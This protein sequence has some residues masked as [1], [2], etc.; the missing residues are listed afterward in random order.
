MNSF[1]ERQI[2]LWG[3]ETQKSLEDKSIAIIG[4]GGL[5]CSLGFA[6]ASSGIGQIYLV[7]FDEVSVNNI[8]RQIGFFHEDIKK[9]K[10]YALKNVLSKRIF[11]DTKLV[12]FNGKFE[13]FIAQDLKLDLLIDAT[14]NLQTRKE[15]NDFSK[16]IS[17][18]WLY[19]SVEEWY[20]QVCLFCEANFNDIFKQ[21]KLPP[22]G[23][24]AP[25]V[26]QIASFSAL[27]GLRYLAG[28]KVKKDFL[29]S[30][31]FHE[32]DFK[33]QGFFLPNLAN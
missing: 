24:V 29:Y 1:Y 18:P 12:A 17:I 2:Q 15:I 33:N 10:S 30:I 5:G 9:P 4:C 13:D 28:L 32:E 11:K 31:G 19:A 21:D 8:H 7:D 25:M 27:L 23:Q 26:M 3:E 14:D 20:G 6:L 22:K 16:Q